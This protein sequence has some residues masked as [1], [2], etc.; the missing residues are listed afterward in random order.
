MRLL[1]QFRM[2]IEAQLKEHWVPVEASQPIPP[3]HGAALERMVRDVFDVMMTRQF[4]VGPLP[5]AF[6]TEEILARLRACIA[7]GKPITITLGFAAVKNQN[8][9]AYHRADWAE[10]FALG[11]LAAWHNKVQK[12]YPPGLSIQLL[13]DDAALR[14]AN[15]TRRC[16][17][18]L[19]MQSI[20]K[21]I[22]AMN[23]GSLFPRPQTQSSF[24]WKYHFG[25]YQWAALRVRRWDRDPANREQLEKMNQ[26]AARNLFIKPGLTP[27]EH[28][29]RIHQ[30]S[31][32]YRV[33]WEALQLVG[34]TKSRHRLFATYLDGTQLH[35]PQPA[36]L[37]LTALDK[38]QVTQPWQGEGILMDND[39]GSWEPDVLTAQRQK[40]VKTLTIRGLQVINLQG[41]NTI[42][43]AEPI[44]PTKPTVTLIDKAKEAILSHR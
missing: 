7:S 41:F 17:M 40:Q 38:G 28:A 12:V 9:V 16:D 26:A 18:Q 35:V 36:A 39:H 20:T 23:Y 34:F 29:R 21:L 44:F 6:E 19:Y 33:Y 2:K 8:A 27:F 24:A 43:L 31:H 25:V 22:Q 15:Q 32:R 42:T 3:Q 4:R 37:H 30:A 11:H 5:D 14:M 13:F 1:D 10:F